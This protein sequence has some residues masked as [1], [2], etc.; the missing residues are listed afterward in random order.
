V[1]DKPVTAKLALD[2]ASYGLRSAKVQVKVFGDAGPIE[3]VTE[4]HA[5]QRDI[6]LPALTARAWELTPGP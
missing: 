1:S 5:F 2:A 4:P 6:T 3:T